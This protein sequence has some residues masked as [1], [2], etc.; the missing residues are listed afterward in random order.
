MGN[1]PSIELKTGWWG[2]V[3]TMFIVLVRAFRP[4][5][6]PMEE[7]SVASWIAMATPVAFPW[8]LYFACWAV[9]LSGMAFVGILKAGAAGWDWI[10]GGD[11]RRRRRL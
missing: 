7:W 2:Y 1:R 5:A 10:T 11:I 4:G 6:V 9:Y 8:Y 3:L